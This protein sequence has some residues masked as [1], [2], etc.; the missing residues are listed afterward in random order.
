MN[1]ELELINKLD[2]FME[3]VIYDIELDTI[4]EDA[5]EESE[6]NKAK[7]DSKVQAF[8]KAFKEICKQV[9]HAIK[10]QIKRIINF[11]TGKR[12]FFIASK[13]FMVTKYLFN[14]CPEIPAYKDNSRQDLFYFIANLVSDSRT[15]VNKGD[16]IDI[17]KV[18]SAMEHF[19]NIADKAE[20]QSERLLNA[21]IYDPQEVQ[22][23][24]KVSGIFKEYIQDAETLMVNAYIYFK[25]NEMS[26]A[27]LKHSDKYDKINAKDPRISEIAKNRNRD[28][29]YESA[30]NINELRASL[31]IEAADAL[32]ESAGRNGLYNRY[33]IEKEKYDINVAMNRAKENGDY[34]DYL[35]L[36]VTITIHLK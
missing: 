34:D 21:K 8:W 13:P 36:Y 19:V 12:N 14:P 16:K 24:K 29:F 26:F 31:L 25:K 9:A 20:K 2:L 5:N 6:E 32:E 4:L 23:Y 15:R 18:R 27:P 10:V 35:T 11:I 30:S 1:K 3:N 33:N 7:S 28:S 17:R 22:Y